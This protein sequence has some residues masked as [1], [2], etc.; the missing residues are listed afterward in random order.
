MA[1]SFAIFPLIQE[2]LLLELQS[3][4]FEQSV[5][6]FPGPSPSL[7]SGRTPRARAV[8][9]LPSPADG[10]DSDQGHQLQRAMT[11]APLAIES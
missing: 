2:D 5:E 11:R 1:A 6:K 9:S 10:P 7:F 3:T 4:A 8:M